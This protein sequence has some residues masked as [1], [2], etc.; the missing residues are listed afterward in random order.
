MLL[1]FYFSK[2]SLLFRSAFTDE[3]RRFEARINQLEEELEEEQTNSELN[4]EKVKK[5][6]INYEQALVD[7]STERANTE[8]LE[9][10][11][12]KNNNFS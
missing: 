2:I 11:L 7:L 3:K 9:V 1:N 4:D 8:K 12:T 10:Y 6:A 5:L